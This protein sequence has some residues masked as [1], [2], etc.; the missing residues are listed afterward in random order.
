L[1]GGGARY[2]VWS[3]KGNLIYYV[4]ADNQIMVVS[5]AIKDGQFVPDKPRPWSQF[6]VSNATGS[7]P[8]DTAPDGSVIAFAPTEYER[9]KGNVHVTFLFHFF[10]EVRRR[11]P[12]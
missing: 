7:K 12:R 3:R 6:P 11:I 5:Y 10:D 4:A 9:P 1:S 2:P 8:F